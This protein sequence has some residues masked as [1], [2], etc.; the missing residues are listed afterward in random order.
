MPVTVQLLAVSADIPF[1]VGCS[2]LSGVE[3]LARFVVHPL[4]AT[5]VSS[6]LSAWKGLLASSALVGL[7]EGV[8]WWCVVDI[9][10]SNVTVLLFVFPQ[11]LHLG[12]KWQLVWH[13]CI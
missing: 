10:S 2:L 11:R 4:S 1:V 13:P 8:K 7:G 3:A 5:I 12:I 9:G 6:S